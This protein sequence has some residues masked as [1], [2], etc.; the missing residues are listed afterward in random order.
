MKRTP[1]SSYRMSRQTKRVL[2]TML[3]PQDRSVFK[4]YMIDAELTPKTIPKAKADQT[5]TKE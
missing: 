1:T 3:D 5:E 2:S 4:R